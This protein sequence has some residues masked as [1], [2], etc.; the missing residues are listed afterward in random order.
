[1]FLNA[2]DS[3]LLAG[4]NTQPVHVCKIANPNSIRYFVL[5]K[6]STR[7][8]LVEPRVALRERRANT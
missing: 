6:R 5:G 7:V 4:R 1:M 2:D 3:S 8:S